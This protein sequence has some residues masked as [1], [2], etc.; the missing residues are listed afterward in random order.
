MKLNLYNLMLYILFLLFLYI[1]SLLLLI[2][3]NINYAKLK[4]Y[5]INF[6]NAVK[7]FNKYRY[8]FNIHDTKMC[9]R[10]TKAIIVLLQEKEIKYF[11][12]NN[13]SFLSKKFYNRLIF[14]N[15]EINR[16]GHYKNLAF[17]MINVAK[18][19]NEYPCDFNSSVRNIIKRKRSKWGYQHMIRFYF[20]NIFIHK[21]MCNV[22]WYMRL[23]SDSIFNSSQNPF[24]LVNDSIVYVYNS[25]YPSR[26]YDLIQLTLGMKKF[27]NDYIRYYHISPKNVYNWNRMFL[28]KTTRTYYNNLEIVNMDFFL[29]LEVQ[30]FI[31]VI[32]L[33]HNI[34]H[35]SWGDAPLRYALLSLFAENNE[36]VPFK[37]NDSW[38]YWHDPN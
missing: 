6:Q 2:N 14:F 35:K 29:S 20:K 9:K 28:N 27:L 16:L 15:T 17:E 22:K 1:L 33:S 38:Y 3:Y 4:D 18:L 23:D 10:S 5:S 11:I 19:W 12:D 8:R 34:Y 31:N 36:V 32:D 13:Y 24:D 7:R 21:S 30:K 26:N 37:T 25:F